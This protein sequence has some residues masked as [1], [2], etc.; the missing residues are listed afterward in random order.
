MDGR[1]RGVRPGRRDGR[2]LEPC[3]LHRRTR[4]IDELAHLLGLRRPERHPFCPAVHHVG[5]AGPE[6]S[7]SG[8]PLPGEHPI[9]QAD[10]QLTIPPEGRVVGTPQD[11]AHGV[12]VT[13]HEG[14]VL[15]SGLRR[16]VAS[17]DAVNL[18]DRHRDTLHGGGGRHR[19]GLKVA[20]QAPSPGPANGSP[21][22]E[23]GLPPVEFAC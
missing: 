10:E 9:V 15:L 22:A 7:G 20:P 2:V 1:H 5:R 4:F 21:V 6:A 17:Q 16:P 23:A 18:L 8:P 3:R 11:K 19:L 13:T 12:P 14:G